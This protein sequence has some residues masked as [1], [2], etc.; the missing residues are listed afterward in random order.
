MTTKLIAFDK[1]SP[2]SVINE[3]SDHYKDFDS[4]IVIGLLKNKNVRIINSGASYEDLALL[5]LFLQKWFHN[6]I[7]F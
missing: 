7:G 1:E 3:A 2:L 6:K 5:T 4:V